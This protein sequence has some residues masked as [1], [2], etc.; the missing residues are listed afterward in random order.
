MVVNQ[1]IGADFATKDPDH[2]ILSI[3]VDDISNTRQVALGYPRPQAQV[4]L[5]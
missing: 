3:A 1:A 5:V 4:E 2:P